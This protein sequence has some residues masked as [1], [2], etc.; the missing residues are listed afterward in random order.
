MHHKFNKR[1]T[2]QEIIAC[3]EAPV[4]ESY[5]ES[6]DEIDP[7][8]NNYPSLTI[9]ATPRSRFVYWNGSEPYELLDDAQL[10]ACLRDLPYQEGR[11]LSPIEEEGVG[12]IALVDYS[13]THS[14]PDCQ[15][16]VSIHGENSGLGS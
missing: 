15:V 7:G 1:I 2:N 16:Y 11:P 3:K 4:F 8:L 10:V 5:P 9:I 13:T 14:T 12:D 6:D